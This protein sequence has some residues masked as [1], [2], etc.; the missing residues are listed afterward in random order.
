MGRPPRTNRPPGRWHFTI[1]EYY[2]LSEQGFFRDQKV[3]LIDGEIRV[4][5][6]MNPDHVMGICAVQAALEAIFATGH[7]IR[8]QM[9]LRIATASEPEPDVAVVVGHF[10]DF[11]EHPTTAVLVVEVSDSTLAY[12]LGEKA[13]LY[14]AGGIA[15]YWV[16]NLVNNQLE[17]HRNPQPD[18]TAPHGHHF[19]DVTRHGAGSSVNP[20]AVP[21]ESVDVDDLLP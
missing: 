9:P 13:S 16:L 20:L 4:M 2:Q 3:E 14:A 8:I 11:D 10:R 21:A 1:D 17:V 6:P 18:A 12:D 7:T 15:D 5:S 19:A